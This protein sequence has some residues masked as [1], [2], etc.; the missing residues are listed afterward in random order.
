M[1]ITILPSLEGTYAQAATIIPDETLPTERVTYPG[2]APDM[3][4]YVARPKKDGNYPAVVVIHE[5]RGLNAHIEDVTRRAALAGYL[6][7][8]PDA[9]LLLAER[10][11]LKMKAMQ[12]LKSWM[13]GKTLPILLRRL[14]T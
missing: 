10:P 7:I 6:A 4:A 1:A 8:A 2:A 5:N 9:S 13:P 11:Q 3:K 12:C 14:I